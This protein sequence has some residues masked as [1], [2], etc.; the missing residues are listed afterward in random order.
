MVEE[1]CLLHIYVHL[2]LNCVHKYTDI[3]DSIGLLSLKGI[4]AVDRGLLHVHLHIHLLLNCDHI[5]TDIY[6]NIGLLVLKGQV[7]AERWVYSMFTSVSVSIS[8]RFVFTNKHTLTL[9]YAC[10]A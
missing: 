9:L 5:Y 3:Y 1:V 8:F 4:V 10:L 6:N 2:L 7:V